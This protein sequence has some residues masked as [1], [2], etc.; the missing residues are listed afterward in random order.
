MGISRAAI[1]R[2]SSLVMAALLAGCADTPHCDADVTLATLNAKL[3]PLVEAA[4]G[5]R[6][7]PPI[8]PPGAVELNPRKLAE[9]ARTQ[10]VKIFVE[11]MQTL[12]DKADQVRQCRAQVLLT[13]ALNDREQPLQ[14]HL[15]LNFSM[16][17][18]DPGFLID[19]P[20]NQL[21]AVLK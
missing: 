4:V 15:T 6:L 12:E 19:I 20:P 1:M 2:A 13:L 9:A 14:K 21:A 16:R 10:P 17:K 18:F 5:D 8:I 3:L 7:K 11:S